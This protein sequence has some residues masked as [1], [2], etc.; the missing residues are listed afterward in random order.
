MRAAAQ[1]GPDPALVSAVHAA[2]VDR[3]AK[4]Q[5]GGE[6]R[7]HCPAHA[8]KRPSAD[9]NPDKATW[10][11]RSCSAGGGAV[12]LAERLGVELPRT[13]RRPAPPEQVTVYAIRDAAGKL[14][15]QHVRT[16]RPG[17][18]KRYSWRR[19]G[20]SGLG[21]LL[22]AALPLYGS[23]R[24]AAF[25]RSR[26]VFL[27]EGERAADALAAVGCQVV[28]TVT[29]ASGTP[30]P[31]ALAVLAGLDVVL[32]PD[33]D[34]VGAAHMQRVAAAL[35]GVARS[36]RVWSPAGLPPNGD[37]IEWLAAHPGADVEAA[38]LAEAV[39]PAPA[40]ALA[41]LD[42]GDDDEPERETAAQRLLRRM[43]AVGDLFRSPSGD[44]YIT[45]PSLAGVTETHLVDSA[46]V[47]HRMRVDELAETG[48]TCSSQVVGEVVATL[49]ARASCGTAVRE[50]GQRCLWV[51]G[52]C[53][54]DLADAAGRVVEIDATG[55]RVLTGPPAGVAIE[56]TATCRPAPTP[57]PG[58][59]LAE[60]WEALPGLPESARALVLAWLAATLA[61]QGP[62]PV[63]VVTGEQGSG[64]STLLR[65]LLGLVDPR[66]P[67]LRSLSRDPYDLA[68]A[69]RGQ[70]AIAFDNVSQIAPELSD[71][72]CGLATGSGWATRTLYST[73]GETVWSLSRPLALNGIC[74]L[75]RP[76]LLDRALVATLQPIPESERRTEHDL[77]RSWARVRGRALGLLLTAVGRGIAR[78]PTVEL[79][80]SPR[81]ADACRWATAALEGP[82]GL[83]PDGAVLAAMRTNQREQVEQLAAADPLAAAVVRLIERHDG[84]PVAASPP[85]LLRHLVEGM[86]DDERRQLPRSPAVLGRS[87]R[88]LAPTLR[89]AHGL[90]V[91]LFA[92]VHGGRRVYR[93]ARI[94]QGVVP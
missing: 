11:C 24:V 33:A 39:D 74:D 87:L 35:T 79:A 41:D 45:M 1:S 42:T 80:G 67:A 75:D 69:A 90:D 44:A 23:E 62:Y 64:K 22:V 29:G 47:A 94:V 43:L 34:A 18:G 81:M 56:R 61:P 13:D 51:D 85:E 25:D 58:G 92:R 65:R 88:R 59:N 57:E 3:G 82:G 60:V 52:R 54:F 36:V 46:P 68:I 48:R 9:W 17:A 72:L 77:E 15:A 16:D 12:D 63:L 53:Y 38:A 19:D 84:E 78:L 20:R 83:L 27:T 73:A 55:W 86:T 14:V 32:W 71:A 50:V 21:G 7:F 31:A 93:L 66:F 6:W 8:D 37:A 4:R 26:P 91:D 89:T 10:T 49:A 70:H 2:V 76:D 30:G 40:G 28:A 5:A